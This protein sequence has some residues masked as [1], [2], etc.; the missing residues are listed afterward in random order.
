VVT[1]ALEESAPPVARLPQV[2]FVA[3]TPAPVTF[4]RRVPDFAIPAIVDAPAEDF[5]I[6]AGGEVMSAQAQ[7]PVQPR[8]VA[9]A[10]IQISSAPASSCQGENSS[11][12]Q[13]ELNVAPRSTVQQGLADMVRLAARVAPSLA[14]SSIQSAD[15]GSDRSL[16]TRLPKPAF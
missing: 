10:Q 7:P 5:G 14:P 9:V 8:A 1:A 2:A 15:A 6:R 4:S 13:P 12:L 3:A 11:C 16:V